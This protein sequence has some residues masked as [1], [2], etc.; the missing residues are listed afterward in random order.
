[1]IG[2]PVQIAQDTETKIQL[3]ET[4][5]F[6][7][8]YAYAPSTDTLAGVDLGQDYLT[9]LPDDHS[10][11]F[12]LCDGVGQSF[13][14]GLAAKL[15]GDSIVDWLASKP[16]RETHTLRAELAEH[17]RSLV[18]SATEQVQ[19]QT[20]PEDAS[21]M[22]R[23]VLEQKREM[24]S[25]STFV[26]G[27]IDR[28]GTKNSDGSVVLAWMGDSRLRLWDASGERTGELGDTFQIAQRWS[29]RKGPTVS[30]PNVFISSIEEPDQFSLLAYSDGLAALDRFPDTI[31]NFAV[32][33]LIA[34][35]NESAASDDISFLQVWLGHIPSTI[36]AAPLVAPDNLAT[37]LTSGRLLANWSPVAEATS[38]EIE[39]RDGD[40]QIAET[41]QLEWESPVSE[42]RPFRVRVRARK[43][44]EPGEWSAATAVEIFPPN[45]EKS[46][47][48]NMPTP[49]T[50]PKQ[51]PP[52]RRWTWKV[53]V[54]LLQNTK[55]S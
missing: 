50:S 15:L 35:A 44:F 24:G 18:A 30:E 11:V 42:A 23:D 29:S 9:F 43:G 54:R 16:P 5:G 38:Y 12:A 13:Y 20:L 26:C 45:H 4:A 52:R 27:R 49:T 46:G 10:F 14:G 28:P 40:V 17:L 53:L 51:T 36:A 37:K 34:R 1:M 21:T 32:Q 48:G 22:L 2:H 3:L 6:V 47:E 8:R 55:H 41:E 33:D 31:S 39:I 19:R 25:E 7:L